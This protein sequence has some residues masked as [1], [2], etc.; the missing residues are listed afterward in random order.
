[1]PED[2]GRYVG[3]IALQSGPLARTSAVSPQTHR[4]HD[5]LAVSATSILQHMQDHYRGPGTTG[6]VARR[7][8]LKHMNGSKLARPLQSGGGPHK[9]LSHIVLS[10]I[11]G[12]LD[13]RP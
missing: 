4:P 13:H 1:M 2:G 7:E 3:V 9:L 12:R 8:T 6:V 11:L 5:P 10:S